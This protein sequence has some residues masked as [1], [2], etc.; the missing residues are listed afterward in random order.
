MGLSFHYSGRFNPAQT[1]TNLIEEVKDIASTHNWKY[2]VFEENFPSEDLG[3][4]TY[5]QEN[6]YGICF[7]PPESEPVWLSFLS[8]GR[9]TCP[10]NLQ[11]WSNPHNP[12]HKDYLYM[13]DTK[14]QYAGPEIHALII[15]MLRYIEKKYLLDFTL[16]DEGEYWETGD[17]N[18]LLEVFKRY[19]F[20]IN[21]FV[22][23]LDIKIRK[24]NESLEDYIDRIAKDIKDKE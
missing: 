9:M 19:N 13:L 24:P 4:E 20:F 23:S 15:D 5:H 1:L 22:D 7:S 8:N 3:K 10:P 21:T 16:S 12:A 2:F 18:K 11:L 6:I 14:T 17:K